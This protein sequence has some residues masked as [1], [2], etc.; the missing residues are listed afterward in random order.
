MSKHPFMKDDIS[1]TSGCA[2]RRAGSRCGYDREEWHSYDWWNDGMS[3]QT[4]SRISDERLKE[5]S[6]QDWRQAHAVFAHDLKP[7]VSRATAVELQAYVFKNLRELRALR[8]SHK[9]LVEALEGIENLFRDNS[10]F[11]IKK[12]GAPFTNADQGVIDRAFLNSDAA[13]AEARKLEGK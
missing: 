13:L 2:A 5:P 7:M 4:Q 8:A 9:R 3:E 1:D 6:E 12:L 11:Y 10:A